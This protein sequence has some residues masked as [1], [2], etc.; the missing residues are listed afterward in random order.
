MSNAHFCHITSGCLHVATAEWRSSKRHY[1]VHKPKILSG[2][3]CQPH[4]RT[5]VYKT[6]ALVEMT[7]PIRSQLD[8]EMEKWILFVNLNPYRSS[9]CGSA[10]NEPN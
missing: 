1:L 9:G 5:A 8:I 2:P 3:V 6:S 4:S 7:W 10:V